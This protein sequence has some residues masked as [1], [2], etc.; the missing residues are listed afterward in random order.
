[1]VRPTTQ[2]GHQALTSP[3]KFV[4]DFNSPVI[5]Q[6]IQDLKDTMYSTGLI[7]IAAP[8][9]GENWQIFITEPRQTATRPPEQSDELRIYINPAIIE[10]SSQQS[11]IYEGCGSVVEGQLFGPVTRPSQVTV[12][13]YNEQ[14]KKFR[15]TA[16]G[17]LGRVIQHEYDHLQSSLFIEKVQD[18]KQLLHLEF[19]K[20][21]IKLSPGQ[22]SAS[23]ITVKDY[24]LI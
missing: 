20:E 4:K 13:A 8:Q 5:A 1:M 6:I 2:I 3:N 11:V 9:I 15:L 22:T 21:K 23:H 16:D 10:Y 12:E 17:L 18:L 19:Y 14:G 7:G 24:T